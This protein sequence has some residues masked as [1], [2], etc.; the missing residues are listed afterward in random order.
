MPCR[1]P[2]LLMQADLLQAQ[3]LRTTLLLPKQSSSA[4]LSHDYVAH[5]P[6][7]HPC[8]Q[9]QAAHSLVRKRSLLA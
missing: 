5:L 2:V 4:L 7:L 9:H 1:V 8:H 6:D 3:G